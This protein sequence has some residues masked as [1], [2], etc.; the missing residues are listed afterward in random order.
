[1]AAHDLRNPL[2]NIFSFAGLLER[3]G[4]GLSEEQRQFINYIKLSSQHMLTLIEDLLDVSSIE[5]GSIRLD[6]EKVDFIKLVKDYIYFNKT[7]AQKKDIRL[8]LDT[9][10]EHAE[11]QVDKGK[12]EQVLNNLITNA[13]K[14]SNEGTKLTIGLKYK[15]DKLICSVKDEGQGISEKDI[16]HLFEPFQTT[17]NQ[18]TGG[19]KSTGLG[20]FISKRLINAHQGEI[21]V[22]SKEGKGSTFYFSLPKKAD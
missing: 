14:Y 19:E 11:V 6:L 22:K 1:M 3:D 16:E 15:D 13:I 8:Q 18:T 2:S 17:S 4:V 5:Q 21:W 10:L 20:L 9:S 12:I 7:H